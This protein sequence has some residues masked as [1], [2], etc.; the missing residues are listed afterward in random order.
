MDGPC[1]PC[2]HPAQQGGFPQT[3]GLHPDGQSAQQQDSAPH[4]GGKQCPGPGDTQ[5]KEG[6]KVLPPDG[7]GLPPV[8]LFRRPDSAE[9]QPR[10]PGNHDNRVHVEEDTLL[11][12]EDDFLRTGFMPGGP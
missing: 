12:G 11:P 8:E 5:V 1:H 10:Y 2:G 6:I 3:P 9:S 4:P 7:V